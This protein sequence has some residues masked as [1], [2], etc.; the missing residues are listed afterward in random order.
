MNHDND[1][2]RYQLLVIVAVI[3]FALGFVLAKVGQ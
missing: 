1:N 2:D 3:C